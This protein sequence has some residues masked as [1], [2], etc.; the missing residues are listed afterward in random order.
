MSTIIVNFVNL[1]ILCWGT[2]LNIPVLPIVETIDWRT[3]LGPPV[4]ARCD[5]ITGFSRW[6]ARIQASLLD[7]VP[8][9][10]GISPEAT[11]RESVLRTLMTIHVRPLAYIV[12]TPVST[13]TQVMGEGIYCPY[14]KDDPR[15]G[16]Y[17]MGLQ[18]AGRELIRVFRRKFRG[19][20]GRPSTMLYWGKLLS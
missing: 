18:M 14:P 12:N 16:P 13:L 19:S 9:L 20:D 7:A 5:V 2:L 1:A 11:I 8:T 10:W 17:W 3:L 15:W 6:L 4:R